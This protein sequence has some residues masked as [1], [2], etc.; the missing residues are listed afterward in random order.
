MIAR[1]SLEGAP[2]RVRV[3]IPGIGQ[4]TP[5]RLR[6]RYRPA[7]TARRFGQA[8]DRVA[9]AGRAI[10]PPATGDRMESRIELLCVERGLKMT[11]QRRVSARVLYDAGD[12]V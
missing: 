7:M 11:G 5:D 3:A 4:P 6:R 10:L 8:A 1:R 2:Y 12:C 9:D